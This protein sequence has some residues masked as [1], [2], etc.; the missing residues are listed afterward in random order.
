M[1]E[2]PTGNAKDMQDV[3]NN[4]VVYQTC[5]WH[6]AVKCQ[7]NVVFKRLRRRAVLHNRHHTA[8]SLCF[9]LPLFKYFVWTGYNHFHTSQHSKVLVDTGSCALV[10]L[11][12]R[13]CAAGGQWKSY[14]VPVGAVQVHDHHPHSY[15]H[16][17]LFPSKCFRRFSKSNCKSL[18]VSTAYCYTNIPRC[19]KITYNDS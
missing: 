17:T 1:E 3:N 9:L 8:T 13:W 2:N 16:Q 6:V 7:S 19:N 4:V 10:C 12:C 18:W 5:F 11:G 14:L 15:K